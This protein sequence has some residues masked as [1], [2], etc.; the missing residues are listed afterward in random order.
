MTT[1]FF[2]PKNKNKKPN[3]LLNNSCSNTTIL[4]NCDGASQRR[5]IIVWSNC[6]ARKVQWKWRQNC[7]SFDSPNIGTLTRQQHWHT[8]TTATLAH[9]HDSNIGTLTRQQHWHTHTTATLA[10]SHDSNIGTLTRQQHWHTHTTATL[11][12]SHDSN[13]G[14]L[15]RQQH[16]HTHTTATLAHSHDSNIGTLTRQQHWHTHTTA[17]LAHSHDSN[18]GTLTRQQHWHTHTTATLAHSHDSN[19][20]TLTR[21][22]HWHTHTTATLAHSHDSNIV[23]RDLKPENLVF[24]SSGEVTTPKLTDFGFATIYS[25]KR[26]LNS[27]VRNSRICR[28]ALLSSLSLFFLFCFGCYCFGLWEKSLVVVLVFVIGGFWWIFVVD[29]PK[30]EILDERPYGTSVDMW[31]VSSGLFA[32]FVCSVCFFFFLFVCVTLFC[33][34]THR[35]NVSWN[36]KHF[37]FVWHIFCQVCWGDHLHSSLWIPSIFGDNE[38]ELFDKI[39]CAELQFLSPYWNWEAKDLINNLL[40]VDVKK[41]F[42]FYN[43]FTSVTSSSVLFVFSS[44]FLCPPHR[45]WQLTKRSTTSG[46]ATATLWTRSAWMVLWCFG[47]GQLEWC[48]GWGQFEWSSAAMQHAN[49]EKRFLLSSLQIRWKFGRKWCTSFFW[50]ENLSFFSFLVKPLH[51]PLNFLTIR[52]YSSVACCFPQLHKRTGCF[53]WDKRER[54]N[55]RRNEERM[56]C[57]RT[58]RA[59]EE[60]TQHLLFWF[61]C[62]NKKK[63]W[64]TEFCSTECQFFISGE[65][66]FVRIF[67]LQQKLFTQ[68]N[69]TE[70]KSNIVQSSKKRKRVCF[71]CICCWVKDQLLLFWHRNVLTVFDDKFE[72]LMRRPKIENVHPQN[73]TT[74]C[75]RTQTCAPSSFFVL[76]QFL[77]LFFL[78]LF[79]PS[80]SN[81]QISPVSFQYSFCFDCS[82]SMPSPSSADGCWTL[83]NF[84]W[85]FG[86]C[87]GLWRWG[88]D[89]PN[90]HDLVSQKKVWCFVRFGF[91]RRSGNQDWQVHASSFSYHPSQSQGAHSTQNKPKTHKLLFPQN[92]NLFKT[93]IGLK[94]NTHI[95]SLSFLQPS[96]CCFAC[97][98]ER[99]KFVELLWVWG[100]E[101][102]NLEFWIFHNHTPDHWTGTRASWKNWPPFP[103]HQLT[104]W[105]CI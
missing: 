6:A 19:I 44:F 87:L 92:Q 104:S 103:C 11:A 85:L 21:Q 39:C 69:K 29:T 10:H 33:V 36:L 89:A 40:T 61:V 47:W 77:V 83:L 46:S 105:I 73:S 9:S 81:P 25:K 43:F 88:S 57:D 2:F 30:R 1:C 53:F 64:E 67:L 74:H 101:K 5:R 42:F 17:T 86:W 23:H 35:M 90:A 55:R 62:Q 102:T 80:A 98:F 16:W 100:R 38:Q 60:G 32:L 65:W 12:H 91:F 93:C 54:T 27:N 68:Q 63:N 84:L 41:V 45:D 37:F 66:Q 96:I 97:W 82:P 22:Q 50:P 4:H 7:G 14:T 18:I 31:S 3:Q 56:T 72:S 71:S 75:T 58:N 13:I 79:L 59:W 76:H 94:P 8:H 52:T 48:F 34:H 28:R 70:R 99:I 78:F 20:G 49:S 24:D 15:T 26:P 95:F 51:R